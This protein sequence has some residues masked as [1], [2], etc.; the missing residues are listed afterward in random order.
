MVE[1][2]IL[3]ISRLNGVIEMN[4]EKKFYKLLDMKEQLNGMKVGFIDNYDILKPYKIKE[5]MTKNNI[6]MDE[7]MN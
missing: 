5:M 6:G 4:D 3:N 7:M 2:Q 1:D